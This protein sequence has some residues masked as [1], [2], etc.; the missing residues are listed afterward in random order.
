MRVDLPW[1]WTRILI[2]MAI[3]TLCTWFSALTPFTLGFWGKGKVDEFLKGLAGARLH[4]A[5]IRPEEVKADISCVNVTGYFILFVNNYTKRINEAWR[6]V[7]LEIPF[8]KQRIDW[9]RAAYFTGSFN[10]WLNWSYV[11]F[12]RK[13]L[14]I[15][16]IYSILWKL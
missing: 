11:R 1:N 5:F 13:F 9:S 14:G 6:N 8:V 3:T 16:G 12:N 4:T 15:Y 7:I 2:I 10:K